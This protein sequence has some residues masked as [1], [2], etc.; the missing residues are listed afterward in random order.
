[1]GTIKTV[2]LFPALVKIGLM[3]MPSKESDW[4]VINTNRL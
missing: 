2:R 4:E 1:M 3:M